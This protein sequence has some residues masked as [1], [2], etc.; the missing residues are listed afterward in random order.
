MD[1]KNAIFQRRSVRRFNDLNLEDN[2]IEEIIKA[3]LTAPSAC[4]KKPLEYY[5][6]KNEE[7]Q[8]LLRK[9]TLFTNYK[10]KLIIVVCGNIKKSLSKKDN[11]FWTHDAS[12]S[13]ENMLI[14]ATSLNVGSCWCGLYPMEG[15]YKKVQKILNLDDHNIPLGL[16]HFGYTDVEF[17]EKEVEIKK[18]VHFI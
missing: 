1:A 2:V 13:I 18:N 17:K 8:K 9:S 5:V 7:V 16:I 6:V 12:A 10:S 11:D 4:N 15:A 3:G 14:M